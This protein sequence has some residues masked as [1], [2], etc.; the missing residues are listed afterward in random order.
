MESTPTGRS[1][2]TRELAPTPADHAVI[3]KRRAELVAALRPTDPQAIVPRIGR[4]FLRFPSA[5]I[6]NP[7][8]TTAAY[9]QDL[10]EF[11]LWAIES[12]IMSILRGN[13]LTSKDFAP[14]SVV[15][16]D[17][18]VKELAKVQIE[19]SQINKVLGVEV[20]EEPSSEQRDRV[21]AMLSDTI[22]ELSGGRRKDGLAAVAESEAELKTRMLAKPAVSLS[23]NAVSAIVSKYART[24]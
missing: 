20:V 17:A 10:A 23:P 11:P 8:A 2:I 14:S 16:R 19:L 4:L 1:L 5:K 9:A 7:A 13:G 22:A 3:E 21:K 18:V 6:E 24:A 12:G 15:V